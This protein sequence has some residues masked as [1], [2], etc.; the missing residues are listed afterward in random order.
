MDPAAPRKPSPPGAKVLDFDAALLAAC[1]PDLREDVI[2]EAAL[3]ADAFAP[4]GRA[5]EL[6]LMAETLTIDAREDGPD[7]ARARLLAAAL[8]QLAS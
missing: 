7:R 8:R 4:E 2:A 1:P 5:E 3:L 6:R